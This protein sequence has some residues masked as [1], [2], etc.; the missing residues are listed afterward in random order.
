MTKTSWSQRPA[1]RIWN[2]ISALSIV[3]AGLIL[4]TGVASA[5]KISDV[6]DAAII[7]APKTGKEWLTNGLDYAS[8]RF[9]TLKQINTSNAKKLGLAWSYELKTTRGVQAT[10]IVVDGVMYVSGPWSVVFA[11]DARTGKKLWTF[12]PEVPRT[13][14]QFACCDVGNRGVAVY[15]GKV[16]VAALDARLI[17]LEAGTGKKV[18]EV[19]TGLDRARAYSLTDFPLVY[20]DKVIV[21]SAGNEYG[22]RGSVSA[23]DAATGA[24]KWRWYAVP[25]D[26]SKGF[27]DSSQERAAATWDPSVKWWI[28]GGGGAPWH[29]M[30]IDPKLGLVYFGT[31]QGGPWPAKLRDPSGGENLYTSSIVALDVKTGKYAWHYQEVPRDRWDYDAS[32]DLILADI[33][34]DGQV[35]KVIMHAPKN[36]FFFVLDRTNGKFISAEK[37]VDVVNWASGY[38]I[39]GKPIETAAARSPE[40]TEAIPGPFGA[41]NW[42]AMSYSPITGLVYI[43]TQN[44]PLVLS[45][46]LAWEQNKPKPGQPMA[47]IGANFGVTVNAKPPAGKP[48]G[49]LL[50]WDPVKQ[51]KAWVKDY[52]PTPFN[53][54]TLATAGNLVFQGTADGHFVVYNATTGQELWKTRVSG[55]VVAAPVTYELDGKQYVSIAVGWGG[56]YGLAANHSGYASTGK[57]FTFTLD[58]KAPMP[59][60]IKFEPGPLVSGVKYDP[61]DIDAGAAIYVSNCIF[62]HGVPGV[63]K[64]G[65]IRNLGYVDKHFVEDIDKYLLNHGSFE[66]EGMPDF[67]G[68]L[69]ADDIQKIKAFIQGVSDSVRK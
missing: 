62:C 68:K 44:V 11:M 2:M 63:D 50:A 51:K 45:D 59:E 12:D 69:T 60:F 40:P 29:G 23:W 19:Y 39:N 9:S 24:L 18:W 5:T 27:E 49:Q 33:K 26:P 41:H 46:D 58:G 22:I 7:S 66:N 47:G 31:G 38:D 54:G 3:A 15:K 65:A 10:P 37:F 56:V 42:H 6:N 48:W 64:G 14:G 8:T 13:F 55:G 16:Y 21:G 67:T 32:M 61:K 20:D 57:V 28:N 36:G 34:I 25:G 30:S 35:R 52:G 43:P 4:G 53:G 1:H 17:A